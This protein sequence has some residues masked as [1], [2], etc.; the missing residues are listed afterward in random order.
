MARIFYRPAVRRVGG[1]S[2]FV[3]SKMLFPTEAAANVEA[4]RLKLEWSKRCDAIETVFLLEVD[5]NAW[6]PSTNR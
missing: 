4:N 3:E 1:V 2:C 6:P 5:H